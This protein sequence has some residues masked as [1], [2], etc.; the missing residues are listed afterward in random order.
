MGIPIGAWSVLP[1]SP[2]G[3]LISRYLTSLSLAIPVYWTATLALLFTTVGGANTWLSEL[4]PVFVLGFGG[5]G[6]IA[7]LVA[8]EIRS[9]YGSDFVRVARAKGLSS[10]DIL[11]GHIMRIVILPTVSVVALQFGWL[12]SGAVMTEIIFNRPG[13]GRLLFERT[14]YQDYTVVQGIVIFAALVFVIVNTAAEL[15]YS[16]LDPRIR[17]RA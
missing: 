9:A 7:R 17:V 6:S 13:L 3:K 5:M 15:A 12:M 1:R 2:I 10:K 11:F 16:W 14:L 8:I 4:L